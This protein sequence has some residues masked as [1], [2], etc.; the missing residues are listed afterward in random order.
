VAVARRVAAALRPRLQAAEVG[1]ATPWQ[2]QIVQRDEHLGTGQ[3]EPGDD[4]GS[5]AAT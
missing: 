1:D 3:G 2:D 5:G 4:R